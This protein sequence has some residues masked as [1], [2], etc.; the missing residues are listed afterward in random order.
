M[1]EHDGE[2]YTARFRVNGGCIEDLTV[3][4]VDEPSAALW[5]AAEQA[6]ENYLSG[7]LDYARTGW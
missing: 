5:A 3:Q 6:A 4:G 1:F 2:E 7:A